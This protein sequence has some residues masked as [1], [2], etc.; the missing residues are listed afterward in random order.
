MLTGK[1]AFEGKSQASLIG[2]IMRAMPLPIAAA[3][4]L[5]PAALD[6]TVR[7][8]LA[9]DPDERWQSAGDLKRELQWI[10]EGGSQTVGPGRVVAR[11]NARKYLAWGLATLAMLV[12]IV[13][14]V[15]YLRA[16]RQADAI[17]RFTYSHPWAPFDLIKMA[18]RL[19]RTANSSRLP[20]EGQRACLVF[21]SGTSMRRRRSR[22]PARTTRRFPSGRP[23]AGRLVLG[24]MVDSIAKRLT[25]PRH[26]GSAMYRETSSAAGPGA[27]AA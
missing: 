3:Q 19:R 21:L 2:A 15:L 16:P 26:A 7:I 22:L 17:V 9:K 8:C 24:K 5:A 6:R 11:H 12:A 18:L 4:P 20:R 1:K 10:A 14:A 13:I 23:I 25:A 27:R